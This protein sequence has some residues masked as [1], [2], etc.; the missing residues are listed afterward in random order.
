M[1][2]TA[3][4]P[5]SRARSSLTPRTANSTHPS[6]ATGRPPIPCR[7]R[8]N[9][10]EAELGDG[11]DSVDFSKISVDSHLWGQ[12]GNDT[13]TGGAGRDQLNGGAGA[14]VFQGGGG[15]DIVTYAD[16]YDNLKLTLDGKANIESFT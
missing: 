2:I 3:T 7:T 6:P 9:L 12:G 4:S 16:R 8:I 10:I 15:K 14:D 11:N 5:S 1:T 13:L